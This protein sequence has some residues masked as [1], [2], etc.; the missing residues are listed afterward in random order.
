MF[1]RII[2]IIAAILCCTTIMS[3]S[4]A[5]AYSSQGKT[6][7]QLGHNFSQKWRD[8]GSFTINS[9]SYNF[10]YGY[11]T[12]L[13]NEDYIE[14]VYAQKSGTQY[15]GKVKNSNSATQVTNVVKGTT[16][17]GNASVR[18]TGNAATY[19]VYACKV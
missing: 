18:H 3:V 19:Y 13:I 5:A 6:A 15:Y 9:V 16:K 1:K 11:D 8:Y 10:T 2:S 17:T 7:A 12:F 14:S 4:V